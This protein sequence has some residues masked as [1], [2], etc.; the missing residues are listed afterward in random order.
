M[1]SSTVLDLSKLS[2]PLLPISTIAPTST[3]ASTEE[4]KGLDDSPED[5]E[6]KYIK[7]IAGDAEIKG[8]IK[9][10]VKILREIA[11]ASGN[12]LLNTMIDGDPKEKVFHLPNIK[13]AV[14]VKVVE[15]MVHHHNNPAKEIKKPIKSSN[16][17]EIVSVWDAAYVDVDQPMLFGLVLAANYLDYK[18]L[19]DLTCAKVAAMI[20][21][22]SPE[23]LRKLF[24]IVNDFTPDE[25]AT[26]ADEAKWADST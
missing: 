21:G 22:K 24:N 16:M 1:T 19:L 7:L 17:A 12:K 14:L 3:S 5:E 4:V 20:K 8:E 2:A 11:V 6:A 9:D 10:D 13:R 18:D 23:E 26:L 15:Y 25:E